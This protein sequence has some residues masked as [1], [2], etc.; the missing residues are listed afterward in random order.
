M[1]FPAK[2]STIIVSSSVFLLSLSAYAQP[3]PP[4]NYKGEPNYKNEIPVYPYVNEA[5]LRDG[6]YLGVGG[7]Y[8]AYKIRQQLAVVDDFGNYFTFDPSYSAKGW[9]AS[10][11]TGYGLYFNWFYF[12]GEINA[13]ASAA[14]STH[15]MAVNGFTLNEELR[16]RQSYGVALLPG[17]RANDYTLIYARLGY[18]RTSMRNT[19]TASILGL[20]TFT[21]S[22]TEWLNG[23]NYG[24]GIETAICQNTSIRGE[25]TY[26]SYGTFNN[27]I[28][29]FT[30][31]NSSFTLGVNYHFP[32]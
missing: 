12:G 14:E 29:K 1:R 5:I 32:C 28:T 30:P 22:V 9:N 3:H 23:F 24:V 15:T 17:F 4:A 2:I 31:N 21:D 26:T 18:L 20:G 8:D 6:F 11:F 27:G 16:A 7:G 19:E 10:A 13:V 25:Y